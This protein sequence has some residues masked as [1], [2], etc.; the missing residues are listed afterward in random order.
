[1]EPLLFL[2]TGFAQVFLTLLSFLGYG[3]IVQMAFRGRS[4]ELPWLPERAFFA[5]VVGLVLGALAISEVLILLL[6]LDVFRSEAIAVVKYA[7]VALAL[8]HLAVR[9]DR[10]LSASPSKGMMPAAGATA[11]LILMLTFALASPIPHGDALQY[12]LALPWA[13]VAEQSLIDQRGLMQLGVYLGYD[14]LYVMVGDLRALLDSPRLMSALSIFNAAS[15]VLLV[16]A[17]YGLA[18]IFGASRPWSALSALCLLTIG[19]VL[20]YWG[21]LKNDHVAAGMALFALMLLHQAWSASSTAGLLLASL[22]AAFSITIK[23]STLVP[24]GLPFLFVLASGRFGVRASVLVPGIGLAVMA[25]WLY[26]ATMFQGSPVYPIATPMPEEIAAGWEA[27]NANG[28]PE[29]LASALRNAADVFLGMHPISGNQSVGLPF[30]FAA[31]VSIAGLLAAG[32]R[33]RFGLAEVIVASSLAWLVIFYLDRFDGRFLSR[34]IIVCGGVFFAYTAATL[35]RLV[36]SPNRYRR[37]VDGTALVLAAALIWPGISGSKWVAG[38][39]GNGPIGEGMSSWHARWVADFETWTSFHRAVNA[40]ADGSGV[41]VNDHFILF[42]HGPY[43]NLHA[44][45]ARDLN[46]YRKDA[47]DI[48]ALLAAQQIE[49]LVFRRN[50]SGSTEAVDRL[51]ATCAVPVPLPAEVRDP[52]QVYAIRPDC[53]RAPSTVSASAATTGC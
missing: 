29:G 8:G 21:S 49:T 44:L 52:R 38:V 18:R 17:T 37:L 12:H 46:L 5:A 23:I 30:L 15:L 35:S 16:S 53:Q 33:R 9:R 31:F 11:V 6:L 27:R 1:M 4:P 32:T 20:A 36:N 19:A 39:A 48:R 22:V 26:F 2:L 34:Y 51:L 10:I 47:A 13:F 41:A 3:M 45:H 43:V 50:I 42:L 40:V 28:L 7:G 24:V 14:L 25:P